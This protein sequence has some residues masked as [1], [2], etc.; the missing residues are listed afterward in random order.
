[1]TLETMLFDGLQGMVSGRVYPDVAPDQTAPPYITYQ[2]VG[3]DAINYASGEVPDKQNA[4]VQVS[5]WATSRMEA[6]ALGAQAETALRL[7]AALQT[8]VLGA[9]RARHDPETNLRGTMQ[10]FSFWTGNS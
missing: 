5:V 4:R 10:D 7:V 8:T 6:S 1:M 2:Q 9:R 3:G